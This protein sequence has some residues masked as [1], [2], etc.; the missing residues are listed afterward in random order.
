MKIVTIFILAYFLI[1]FG[2]GK[3]VNSDCQSYRIKLKEARDFFK[4]F[5]EIELNLTMKSSF[6][7]N[8]NNFSNDKKKL[9]ADRLTLFM[10]LDKT[11]WFVLGAKEDCFTFWVNLEPDRFIE[12][13]DGKSLAESQGIWRSD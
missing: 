8:Y 12:L 5:E 10:L 7:K 13:I 2:H 11:E 3:E 6:I 1:F 9:D 4:T